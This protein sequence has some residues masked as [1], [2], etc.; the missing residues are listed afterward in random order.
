MVNVKL[1][2]ELRKKHGFTY[3]KLQ[4]LTGV[5][6]PTLA[7]IGRYKNPKVNVLIALCKVYK[8]TLND[9]VTVSWEVEAAVNTESKVA[10]LEKEVE[11]LKKIIELQEKL[12]NQKEG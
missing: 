11:N 7:S 1:I 9:L 3:E 4:E 6:A 2:N 12:L 8:M 5:P 10:S